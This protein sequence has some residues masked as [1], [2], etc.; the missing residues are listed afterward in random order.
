[1]D[2]PAPNRT[3]RL[4]L[5]WCAS[6]ADHVLPS[7]PGVVILI[8]HRVGAGASIESDLPPT[9]FE[10]QMEVLATS[11]RVVSLGVALGLVAQE[12]ATASDPIVITFDDGTEDFVRCALP[13]LHRLGL[14]ST[15]YL[16]TD[17]IESGR[18]FLF[19]GRPLSWEAVRE[20]VSTGLVTIG[21]HTHTHPRLDRLDDALVRDE[22]DRSVGLIEDRVGVHP[23]DFAYPYSV[24]GLAPAQ[25]AVKERFR[26][27]ALAG[28]R[29][30]GY[31]KTDV[32]R[33]QRTPIQTT[34]GMRF[35]HKKLQGGMWLE[36][37]LRQ[38]AG[39]RIP[40]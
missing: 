35:F 39:P 33:L 13:V 30:N 6:A 8:Y 4:T 40:G 23:E 11:R 14:E 19:Q 22:L 25:A 18:E 10:E 7:S 24:L 31:M 20:A 15:I 28:S 29:P 16:A 38:L 37:R 34:D 2:I 32:H 21:A 36:D 17:F 12:R 27:A 9:V 3:L 26:S 5:K 1:M